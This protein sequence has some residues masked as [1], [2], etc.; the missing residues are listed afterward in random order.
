MSFNKKKC[1]IPNYIPHKTPKFTN[2][3]KWVN[4]YEYDLF[5]MY[6]IFIETLKFRYQDIDFDI[7]DSNEYLNMFIN[8]MFD[9]SSK[10]IN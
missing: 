4:E 3:Y 5:N 2:F 10:I 6:S 1:I 8:F 7:L 9:S